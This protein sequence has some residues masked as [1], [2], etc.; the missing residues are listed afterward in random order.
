MCTFSL[1]SNLSGDMLF[2]QELIFCRKSSLNRFVL[3]VLHIISLS[4]LVT[5]ILL[6]MIHIGIS[7]GT[8][9]L[10]IGEVS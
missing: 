3:I 4:L 6:I 5:R 9:T 7:G 10:I 1:G 8:I 2:D